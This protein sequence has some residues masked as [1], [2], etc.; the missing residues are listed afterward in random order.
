MRPFKW[1]YRPWLNLFHARLVGSSWH[2]VW[3]TPLNL[4][5]THLCCRRERSSELICGCCQRVRSWNCYAAVC[6]KLFS[7]LPSLRALPFAANQFL[8]L[9][10]FSPCSALADRNWLLSLASSDPQACSHGKR[11]NH[12]P[13][14]QYSFISKQ[15][16]SVSL[17]YDA[18]HIRIRNHLHH[19]CWVEQFA[20]MSSW[21]K[22]LLPSP[23][24]WWLS[25]KPTS[26]Y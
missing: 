14:C 20:E 1:V 11:L 10:N 6:E 22:I 4:A 23:G 26:A 7:S 19:G 21:A 5:T 15:T 8:L 2:F 25:L 12:S 17:R 24:N 18:V 13:G 9:W 3:V 16:V